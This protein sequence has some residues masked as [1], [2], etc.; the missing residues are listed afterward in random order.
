MNEV[1]AGGSPHAYLDHNASSAL[2]PEAQAA[3]AAAWGEAGN[4][5]SVHGP[6]RAARRRLE[7]A[8]AE[9][10]E[11]VGAEAGAVVFTSGATEANNLALR[12]LGVTGPVA[13]GA[14]V[15]VGATEHPSV[16][17]ALRQVQIVPVD[18]E[19]VIDLAALEERLDAAKASGRPCRL[20]ALML[21]N[22]ETGVLQPVAAAADLAHR[23]GARLH[24]DA[25]QAA[26]R[27]AVD[28]AELGCDSLALSAHKLGGPQGVGA[29]VLREG[30][31][32]DPLLCG[33][34]QENGRRA[35]TENVAGIAGF[36]AAATA[37]RAAMA[38]EA[39]AQESWR[40]K[41]ER[42]LGAAAPGLIVAGGGA[43]RL[44]NTACLVMPGV[45][46]E[47]QV[48]ALDLA[49]VAVSAGAA[50]ASGKVRA[51]HVLA[52]MGQGARAAEAIRVSLGWNTRAEDVERLIAAWVSLYRR[53]R[54]RAA[55]A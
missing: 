12:G 15:L 31:R 1:L 8:R 40:D 32:L 4:P 50:C 18:G 16:L 44:P 9:V 39:A 41:I 13:D 43:A 49:G 27:I 6:G 55:A 17:E 11:L 22:N 26:G 48:M 25:A 33:G 45:A 54:E 36:A 21:A 19:G 30:V 2:R 53:T 20:V 52:A 29:L 46:A 37:A 3:M 23:F 47:T 5:S 42:R 7:A 38:Q 28:V 10:A 34:R 35:G 14:E 24:C 51:S